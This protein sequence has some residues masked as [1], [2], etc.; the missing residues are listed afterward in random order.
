MRTAAAVAGEKYAVKAREFQKLA[1]KIAEEAG[2]RAGEKE[3]EKEV[4][5]RKIIL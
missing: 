4:E 2:G 1:I 5:F 3:G